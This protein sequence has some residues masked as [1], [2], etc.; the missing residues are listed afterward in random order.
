[1]FWRNGTALA[2][3]RDEEWPGLGT[4]FES[5]ECCPECRPFLAEQQKTI[6]DARAQ[7]AAVAAPPP[8]Q[9]DPPGLGE[10]YASSE[11]CPEC[12]PFLDE[13]RKTIARALNKPTAPARAIEKARSRASALLPDVE[14]PIPE[15]GRF[16]WDFPEDHEMS[17]GGKLAWRM[18]IYGP[19][20]ALPLIS[21]VLSPFSTEQTLRHWAA[22][23]GC[24]FATLAGV[25]P[26]R[27]DQPGYHFWLDPDN[28]GISC[29]TKKSRK[30][31]TGGRHF[32][33]APGD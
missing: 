4:W 16:E 28:D 23:A 26:S 25:A 24:P 1:M 2:K 13:Q 3:A 9:D 6:A 10:W 14:D 20:L 30:L 7:A 29:E 17:E 15:M 12:Q 31:S 11:T 22:M 21:M 8:P 18:V 32:F 27:I 19:M 33:R 5:S